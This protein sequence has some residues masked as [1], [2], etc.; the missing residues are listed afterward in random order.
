MG[1]A[2]ARKLF[3]R[4]GELIYDEMHNHCAIFAP[5]GTYQQS[6]NGCAFHQHTRTH[7]WQFTPPTSQTRPLKD[8]Q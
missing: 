8:R 4:G 6:D 2:K 5:D 3:A 1:E 7:T